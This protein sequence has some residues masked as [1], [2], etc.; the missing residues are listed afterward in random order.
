MPLN[1]EPNPFRAVD[2][3]R[4]DEMPHS[5]GIDF[6]PILHRWE[7]FRLWY[8]GILIVHTMLWSVLFT[9]DLLLSGLF[10][11]HLCFLGLL[12]NLCF[13]LG[14]ALEAYGRYFGFWS[15][16]L[17]MLLFLLGLAFTGLLDT[18]FLI[19]RAR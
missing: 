8:N 17:S 11:F 13:F 10:W 19:V 18:A 5:M 1:S 3:A 9:P 16:L 6:A 12:C 15:E 7:R 2:V 14:P 4:P